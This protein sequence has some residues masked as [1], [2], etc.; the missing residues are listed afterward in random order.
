MSHFQGINSLHHAASSCAVRLDA[1][2]LPFNTPLNRYPSEQ[3]YTALAEAWGNHERIPASCIYFTCG[4][5]EAID[6]AQ[7]IYA[8]Q[9]RD[10]VLEA[11][12]TR[13]IYRRRAQLNRLECRDVPLTEDTWQLP[14]NKVLDTASP[15]TKLLF[16]CSPNSPTGTLHPS[17]EVCKLLEQFSGMVIVDESYIDFS[18]HATLLPL[19]NR[20]K[21]LVILRSF[22][23]AWAAAGVRLAAVI[24][25]PE[26]IKQFS[27]F[28]YT[29]PL[30]F[31]VLQ[32]AM[33]LVKNRLDVDKW[34]RQIVT[35]RTKVEVALSQLPEV[36]KVYPSVANFILVKFRDNEEVYRYLLNESI[37][38]RLLPIGIR[39]SIGLP[40]ENSALIG[41][42]R[43]RC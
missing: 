42:L 5:E 25:H 40:G 10:S 3:D 28:G 7:R 21:N 17:D 41:A 14:I 35:E 23:H 34:V 13:S 19:L 31:N 4:T 24:A 38:T 22:S 26:V 39:I 11:T 43:R 2:E 37:A 20:Y 9:G 30:S 36:E 18:P 12:P 29:H 8:V 32:S 15:T 6:L 16:L 1:N 27:N 33:E